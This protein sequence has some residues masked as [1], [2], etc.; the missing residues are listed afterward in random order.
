MLECNYLSEYVQYCYPLNNILGEK[1][2][3]TEKIGAIQDD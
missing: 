2:Q 1:E 3:Y